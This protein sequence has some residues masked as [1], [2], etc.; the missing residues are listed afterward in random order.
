MRWNIPTAFA[1]AVC[2]FST[3]RAQ[4]G[5]YNTDTKQPPAG[6]TV[7]RDGVEA[8]PFTLFRQDVLDLL[9]IANDQ[10]ESPLRKHC[11]KRREELR[12][13]VRFGGTAADRVNL[14]YYL[15]RLRQY[16]QAIG[17]LLPASRQER[18]N[19][20]LLANLATAYQYT[21]QQGLVQARDYL[22]QAQDV[23]PKE[24]PGLTTEQLN[25]YRKVEGQHLKLLR[26]RSREA[27]GQPGAKAKPPETVD[28]LFGV[29]FV[30]DSGEYEPGRLA[31][32]ERAKLPPD[33][34]AQVEQLLVW[35][36][37]DTRLF[38]LLGELLNARGDVSG[39]EKVF[40]ECVWSRRFDAVA[41]KE[42]RQALQEARPQPAPPAPPASWAP[43]SRRLEVVLGVAGLV[44]LLLGYW[45]VRQLFRG[46]K[47][48][49][50]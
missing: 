36:P 34:I 14:G 30:G 11:L 25:W 6:P 20:M 23:W 24:W 44:V 4:A 42:H 12:A 21:G 3:A 18:S 2:L 1:L 5:L 7:T 10:Q 41:L 40:E 9:L 49:K 50:G 46:R 27:A 22:Q 47:A 33:A 35:L 43:D 39:A 19:F 32:A 45:Q 8:L 31:A 26:L 29:R 17:E 28:D 13:K 38:W 16:E 15:I 48:V 37:D